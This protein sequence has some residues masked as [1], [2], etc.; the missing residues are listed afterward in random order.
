MTGTFTLKLETFHLGK[1]NQ[2]PSALE[3]NRHEDKSQLITFQVWEV[4]CIHL[5]LG[6]LIRKLGE[7]DPMF[8][9][10]VMRV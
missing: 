5:S 1:Q 2:V 4:N 10:I 3:S 9:R 7:K 8:Q 6:F